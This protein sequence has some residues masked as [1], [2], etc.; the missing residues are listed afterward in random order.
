MRGVVA[1]RRD[2]PRAVPWTASR[3]GHGIAGIAGASSSVMPRIGV[4]SRGIGP[5]PIRLGQARSRTRLAIPSSLLRPRTA[6]TLG[7]T[8]AAD[9]RS[10]AG[11]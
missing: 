6:S 9:A 2:R 10:E 1:P 3:C 4:A 7:N 8:R 11:G 5:A